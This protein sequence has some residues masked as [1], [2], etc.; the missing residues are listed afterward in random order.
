MAKY[1]E[2]A[3]DIL[4][5]VGGKENVNSLKHCVTRLRFDLKDESKADDDYLK[6]RDG[7]VTVV[8]AG[9]QY[10]VVIGNHVPDVY[11]EVLKVGGIAAGGSL[12]IDEGDGPKGNL[13]DR[14]VSLVSSIFQ[15][16]LGPLAAAGI[17]KGIVAIMAA[18][19]LSADKSSMYVILNAAGDGFFQFLPILIALTSARRFRS[20]NL[21]RLQLQLLLFIQIFQ[22][23]YQH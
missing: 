9:G 22:H 21:L 10:Q 16:F 3:Q 4:A 15:P 17:I 11:D 8:K 23:L 18:C 14:F 6:Q 20:M 19:G 2:L 1:T 13:F 7:V 5:H 12:D